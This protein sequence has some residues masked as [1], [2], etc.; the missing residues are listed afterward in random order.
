MLKT[1]RG[2]VH[3][4]DMK[5]PTAGKAIVELDPSQEMVYPVAQHI[6]A[7]ASPIVEVGDIVYAGQKIA[8]AGGFVSA[9]IHSSVSGTV[10]A[11][12][13]RLH[14]NGLMVNSIVIEDDG[15]DTI[16]PN[17]KGCDDYTQLSPKEIIEIIKEAG[18]V[19]LGGATFPTHVKL[20]PPPEAK[21]DYV[22][23]NAA[24]CEPY[25]TSDY[26]TMLEIPEQIIG[27]LKIV[28]HIFGLKAS[29]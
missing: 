19:G 17:L 23:V 20:S 1:F 13:K 28:M 18:I 16:Y 15:Q 27:G 5:E 12:E 11:I 2:G 4:N 21:I 29:D 6:G 25:L 24:E 14:P 26:R 9:C 3:P 7:P 22:I 10:K 8:E